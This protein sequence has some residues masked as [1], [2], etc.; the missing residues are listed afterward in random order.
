MIKNDQKNNKAV[1]RTLEALDRHGNCLA[2]IGYPFFIWLSTLDVEVESAWG[3]ANS[4]RMRLVKN[5]NWFYFKGINDPNDPRIEIRRTFKGRVST[6]LRTR[7]D[8]QKWVHS[9]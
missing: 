7:M 3:G 5:G 6:V 2:S 9:L 1:R 8:V 4:W